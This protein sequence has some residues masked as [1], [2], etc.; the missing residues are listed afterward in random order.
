MLYTDIFR[1]AIPWSR[2]LLAEKK[3]PDDLNIGI[4]QRLSA[5]TALVLSGGLILSPW[6]PPVAAVLLIAG[7]AAAFLALELPLLRFFQRRGGLLFAVAAAGL[8]L[9]Y[10][11][12]SSVTFAWVNVQAKLSGS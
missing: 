2:L 8:H 5:V 10:Y 11:L 6:L 12:Y 4:R 1:R 3:L 9:T 7:A